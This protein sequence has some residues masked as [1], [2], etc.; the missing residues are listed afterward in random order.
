MSNRLITI[1]TSHFCEKAR[2]ALD[3]LDVDYLEEGHISQLH[4]RSV[5]RVGGTG[6]VPVL[7]TDDGV[8]DDSDDIISWANAQHQGTFNLLPETDEEKEAVQKWM[9]L[10]NE[11]L[12]VCARH[13]G[14]SW[15]F[16]NNKLMLRLAK[17]GVPAWEKMVIQLLLPVAKNVRA[18]KL[19]ITP[20]SLKKDVNRVTRI[21]AKVSHHLASVDGFLVGN[22]LTVADIT[23]AA[24]AGPLILAKREDAL[25]PYIDELPPGAA[26]QIQQWRQTKAGAFIQ[27]LYQNYR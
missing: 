21:F 15:A 26:Y 8:F 23:F 10:F 7:V 9:T 13:I 25:Q 20:K 22:R 6:T 1:T 24:L 5:K 27:S 14:Y 19:N 18:K 17:Q 2:W 11:E 4:R 3:L 12:G 16:Q